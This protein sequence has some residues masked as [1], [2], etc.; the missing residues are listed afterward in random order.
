MPILSRLQN[1]SKD[2]LFLPLF[3]KFWLNRARGKVIC[4]LYHRVDDPGNNSFLTRGGSPVISP[5]ELRGDLKFLRSLGAHFLTFSDLRNGIF[6]ETSEFGV[7]VS[8]DDCF[9]DN[10]T[11]GLELLESLHIKGVFFQTTG[12]ISA[13]TLL[14]EH[15]LYWFNRDENS[16]EAFSH[17]AKRY[18]ESAEIKKQS[19]QKLIEYIR[20]SLPLKTQ[21]TFLEDATEHLT[22]KEDL[23]EIAQKIYPS[24]EL[25]QKAH[26]LGHEIGS[27]GHNHY[28]RENIDEETFE[29]ELCLSAKTIKQ[30]IGKEPEIFSYPFSSYFD[31]DKT[32]CS[33]YFSQAAT[34]DK[35]FITRLSDPMHLPRF[36]WPGSAPNPCRRRRWLLT[37]TI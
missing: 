26:R 30:V 29:Q 4:L 17:F 34:V 1:R 25:I 22:S 3:T 31:G 20:E 23:R 19:G 14:W 35:D 18:A 5:E 16:F 12:M 21:R 11:E 7:I 37:G 9:R 10:Y 32:I 6:P 33:K 24:S 27:H 28:K 36:T 8:F 15:L 13:T 2:L